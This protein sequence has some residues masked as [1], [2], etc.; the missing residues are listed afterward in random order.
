MIWWCDMML[1]CDVEHAMIPWVVHHHEEMGYRP[2]QV[3]SWKRGWS[4]RGI[5]HLA[6]SWDLYSSYAYYYNCQSMLMWF[7]SC[8]ALVI[9]YLRYRHVMWPQRG[10]R[11]RRRL[12]GLTSWL[13]SGTVPCLLLASVTGSLL[14]KSQNLAN[15][16]TR[17]NGNLYIYDL[18][19]TRPYRGTLYLNFVSA[20]LSSEMN[21]TT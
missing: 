11:T 8:T 16:L 12:P 17:L 18:V 21:F 20:L 13:V 9:L 10:Q 2:G 4:R 1:W 15:S 5:C 6:L 7:K 19:L 3:H 14:A